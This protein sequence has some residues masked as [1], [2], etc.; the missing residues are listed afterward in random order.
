[1]SPRLEAMQPYKVRSLKLTK[2]DYIKNVR[3]LLAKADEQQVF[4]GRNH[5]A[6]HPDSQQIIIDLF[7]A[8]GWH[9]GRFEPTRWD[10]PAAWWL[11]SPGE[12]PVITTNDVQ[13]EQQAEECRQP[14]KALLKHHLRTMDVL[15]SFFDQIRGQVPCPRCSKAAP[16]LFNQG[17]HRQFRLQCNGCK[18]RLNQGEAREYLGQLLDQGHLPPIDLA[19][20]PEPESAA[21]VI[22]EIVTTEEEDI[23]MPDLGSNSDSSDQAPI[24]PG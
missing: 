5:A 16:A 9:T 19:P 7:N 23:D 18:A 4:A 13:Q 3:D 14:S 6:A 15:R 17:G 11:H 1:M 22:E 2:E 20:E 12:V 21:V 24:H 8:L 10:D